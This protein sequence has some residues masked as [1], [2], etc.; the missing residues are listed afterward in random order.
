VLDFLT[1]VRMNARIRLIEALRALG[2]GPSEIARR[3]T[4]VGTPRSD[5]AVWKWLNGVT[6]PDNESIQGLATAF[7]TLAPYAIETVAR[8]PAETEP[9][10]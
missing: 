6:L 5:V 7:P 3:L 2:L 1:E 8:R 10:P 9:T 4:E